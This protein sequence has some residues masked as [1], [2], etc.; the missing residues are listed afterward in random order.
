MT[1][2]DDYKLEMKEFSVS[3]AGEVRKGAF[4]SWGRQT[5]SV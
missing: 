1:V 5:G 2:R 3:R 4:F